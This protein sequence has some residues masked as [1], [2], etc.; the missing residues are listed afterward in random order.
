ME[1]DTSP[2][3]ASVFHVQPLYV[4]FAH[5]IKMEVSPSVAQTGARLALD[6][7]TQQSQNVEV[8]TSSARSLDQLSRYL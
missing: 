7:A 6:D 4:A 3:L 5:K 1:H 8:V 2:N